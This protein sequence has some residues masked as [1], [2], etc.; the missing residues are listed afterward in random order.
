MAEIKKYMDQNL[1][2]TR[3]KQRPARTVTNHV[4][5]GLSYS[6]TEIPNN[7]ISF[8]KYQIPMPENQHK[9]TAGFHQLLLVCKY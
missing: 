1:F 2:T 6:V 8:Y 4:L 5:A 3:L 7:Q 9:G